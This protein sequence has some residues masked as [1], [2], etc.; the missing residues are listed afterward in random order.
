MEAKRDKKRRDKERTKCKMV[1]RRVCEVMVSQL[2]M[3]GH[4]KLRELFAS[5][6]EASRT[7]TCV[8]SIIC[9]RDSLPT[10]STSCCRK[11]RVWLIDLSRSNDLI[12][13]PISYPR[14]LDAGPRFKDRENEM[15]QNVSRNL[16]I[17]SN[18]IKWKDD[19]NSRL[20]P[21]HKLLPLRDCRYTFGISRYY[22]VVKSISDSRQRLL[23][24]LSQQRIPGSLREHLCLSSSPYI[25]PMGI[26][27]FGD[28]AIPSRH[29]TGSPLVP[30]LQ[31]NYGDRA[32]E[33]FQRVTIVDTRE[34][35]PRAYY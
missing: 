17:D 23:D 8:F 30:F 25:S 7:P 12:S 4:V 26:F 29:E 34:D 20:Y 11:P 19:I 14:Y 18:C 9:T 24:L 15:D 28:E 35:I 6:H 22:Y 16:F 13:C 27:I 1:D 3:L 33:I 32:Q 5:S 2:S 21:F 10:L 31:R